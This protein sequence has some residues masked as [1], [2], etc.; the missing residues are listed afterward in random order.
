MFTG[1]YTLTFLLGV[2][3]FG[4][5]IAEKTKALL[6]TTLVIALTL[7]VSFWLGLPKDIFT[8]SAVD[9]MGMVLV[10]LLITSM[11]T[12]L[13]IPQ[14]KAQ[15]KTILVSIV[16]VTIGVVFILLLAP[17]LIGRDMALAG[18]PIFA[19]GNA[20]ALMMKEILEAKGLADLYKFSILMLITQS[21]IGIPIA[22]Y[23]LRKEARNFLKSD[24]QV[25][26]EQV[27]EA[28]G[29]KL[30]NLPEI[31]NKPSVIMTKLA[32]VSILGHLV[33]NFSA[34][35][36][37]PFISSLILGVIFTELGFLEKDI[38]QKTNSATFIIFTTTVVIF[39]NLAYTS[40]QEI[41]DMIFPLFICF[42]LGIIGVFIAGYLASKL[43]KISSYMAISLILTCTF[44]FPTTMLM[45]GEIAVAI[46]R[47][48]EERERI[49]NYLLPPMLT[50]GFITV[51]VFSV[52]LTGFLINLL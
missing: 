30:I 40:P 19:G 32:M 18:A 12:S 21:F 28:E 52:I 49:L 45:P 26:G 2:F 46:G 47:T 48:N 13:N 31:F 50:A 41:L 14:L 38:L 6:S 3:A 23:L 35:K 37:H 27:L 39:S 17:K 1:I 33:A 22:S 42:L 10:S 43:F 29:K 9:T 15:W 34:G 25:L 11:G 20:S 7:L 16:G 51:T 36:I 5:I 24:S 8:S 44:G 4:E